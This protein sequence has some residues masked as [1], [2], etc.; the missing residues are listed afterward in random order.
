M[1]LP[2]NML[3][4][5]YARADPRT[6][7]RLRAASTD[8]RK[9][10][11]KQPMPKMPVKML[12]NRLHKVYG[13]A[14]TLYNAVP[15]YNAPEMLY[16]ILSD[17]TRMKRAL[18]ARAAVARGDAAALSTLLRDQLRESPNRVFTMRAPP[19]DNSND[20]AYVLSY[21]RA[22]EWH[23]AN[24]ARQLKLSN[25]NKSRAARAGT[26][27][28]KKTRLRDTVFASVNAAREGSRAQRRVARRAQRRAQR[29][30]AGVVAQGAA[31]TLAVPGLPY[32]AMRA[33]PRRPMANAIR[34]SA[35]HPAV[36]G[37]TTRRTVPS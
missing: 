14:M 5:I 22:V 17:L 2:E 34:A 13:R 37:F 15:V 10:F 27:N 25:A 23:L 26:K 9:L 7:I 6:Q 8:M 19:A 29:P 4:E 35:Q 11:A 16:S 24:L 1:S 28:L 30:A 32:D 3:R 18:P 20:Q 21:L 33:A 31:M 36:T 12:T